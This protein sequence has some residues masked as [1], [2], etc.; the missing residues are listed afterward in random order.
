[1]EYSLLRIH[2]PEQVTK[3]WGL[4]KQSILLTWPTSLNE[5]ALSG[6]LQSLLSDKL[7]AWGLVDIKSQSEMTWKALGTTA[8]VEDEIT[9]VRTLHIY[10]ICVLE[11]VM[12]LEVWK[13]V[14]TKFTEHAKALGCSKVS[15]LTKHQRVVDIV[16]SL[17]GDA[18]TRLI[19]LEV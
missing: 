11:G 12:E 14:W 3:H 18:T 17:G 19:E 2:P 9:G 13:D 10:H 1:V 5:E 4:L 15:A 7:Q 6:I 16:E 8:V